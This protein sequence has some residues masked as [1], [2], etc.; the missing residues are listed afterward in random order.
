MAKVWHR[1]AEEFAARGHEVSILARAYSGQPKSEVASGVRYIRW[2]GFDQS[3]NI[4]WDLWRDFFYAAGFFFRLPPAD[5][6]VVNDFWLPVFAVHRRNAGRVVVSVNRFPKRQM[7]LYKRVARLAAASRA[8]RDAIIYQHPSSADL[9]RVIPN[10]VDV[11]TLTSGTEKSEK[12]SERTILFVGRLH[13]EK[14]VHVLVAAC[15]QLLPSHPGLHLWLVGPHTEEQGGGGEK[16]LARLK[17]LAGDA[18]V[19]ISGPVFDPGALAEVYRSADIFCYPSLA[20][21]GEALPV[22][23]LEAMAAGL[24]PVVSDLDC[25]RDFIEEGR[26]GLS[27]D[28]RKD[29]E[30]NLAAALSRLLE[31]PILAR[32]IGM[33]ASRMAQNFS[34]SRIADQFLADFEQLISS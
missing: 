10:P 20:E 29:P 14:G 15:L 3:R 23:P 22:A 18:R 13:P 34:V 7:W 28:H 12:K 26:S 9:I 16:Y 32:N 17:E 11:A 27:F 5:I 6:L 8:I 21:Q 25:F 1:L 4:L 24:P 31:D 2:G 33:E 19:E 30:S